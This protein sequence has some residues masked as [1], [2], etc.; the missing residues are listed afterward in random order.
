MSQPE[1]RLTAFG[2][3]MIEFSRASDGRTWRRN[4]AGD[5]FNT[6]WYFRRLSAPGW[7]TAY[8]TAVGDDAPSRDMVDFID[9]AGISTA[10]I[11]TIANASPGLYLI[12]LEGAERHFSYWRDTSAARRLAAD[13][14]HLRHAMDASDIV[15]F[16]GITLAILPEKDR[17]TFVA[18]L[19]RARRE[20]RTVV[21]DPNI[22]PRLWPG[23]DAMRRALSDAAAAAS[24][25]FPTFPD[26]Q[27]LFGDAD[28]K[29]CADRY[30]ALGVDLVVV[31]DGPLP[32]LAVSAEGTVEEPA[33]PVPCPVDTTGAGDAFNGAFLASFAAGTPLAI[34][35]R[36]A[37]EIAARTICGYGALVE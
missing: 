29:A 25:V 32:C 28:R 33:V 10:F 3:C 6:A 37:H 1:K 34:A 31:K 2:E 21:F 9:A 11:R 15:Y 22:R 12:E 18:E 26:E 35:L 36:K 16:S 5:T 20:G 13:P 4:F 14:V 8:F 30:R 27:A 19:A 17:K 24:I 7:E 23:A